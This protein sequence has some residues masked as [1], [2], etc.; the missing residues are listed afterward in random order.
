MSHERST[1]YSVETIK[2]I[3]ELPEAVRKE[4]VPE[5][6][7]V[8]MEGYNKGIQAYSDKKVAA[9]F[10]WG[11][12]RVSLKENIIQNL[13]TTGVKGGGSK[14]TSVLSI[15]TPTDSIS[16]SPPVGKDI[17]FTP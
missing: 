10:A 12:V 4:L 6:Q 1:Y 11:W 9:A 15:S 7:V 14:S 16:L 13:I 3:S 17:P 2:T 8:W 5:A